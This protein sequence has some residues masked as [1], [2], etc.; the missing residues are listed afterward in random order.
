MNHGKNDAGRRGK[1]KFHRQDEVRSRTDEQA[2][3][4][5]EAVGD[6]QDNSDQSH[7]QETFGHSHGQRTGDGQYDARSRE[8]A[9][10]DK[11]SLS[12]SVVGD[13]NAGQAG[14]ARGVGS[15]NSPRASASNTDVG[16]ATRQGAEGAAS[17]DEPFRD[18]PLP[19]RLGDRDRRERQ[20]SEPGAGYGDSER[21]QPQPGLRD[22]EGM[23]RESDFSTR[24]EGGSR[25]HEDVARTGLDEQR[26]RLGM[27]DRENEERREKQASAGGYG[28]GGGRREGTPKGEVRH[29]NEDR[30]GKSEPRREK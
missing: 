30:S 19:A 7:L 21:E 6:L 20:V 11:G 24:D 25:D 10:P 13:G 5:R 18:E 2:R 22:V 15:G 14:S 17:G 23:I 1:G 8:A 4:E 27:S 9:K 16:N 28:Y 12:G 3:R 26:E 29:E